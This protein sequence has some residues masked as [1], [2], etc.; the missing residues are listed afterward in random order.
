MNEIEISQKVR[1]QLIDI[2]YNPSDIFAEYLVNNNRVDIVI[3]D[4]GKPFIVIEVKNDEKISNLNEIE[5]RFNPAVRQAQH[6]ANLLKAPYFAV[7]NGITIKWYTIGHDGRPVIISGPVHSGND[8]NNSLVFK[9]EKLISF[10]HELRNYL[11]H[12]I[13]AWSTYQIS[14][15]VYSQILSEKGDT[16]LKNAVLKNE[17]EIDPIYNPIFNKETNF[18]KK[19][20]IEEVFFRLEKLEL[21]KQTPINLLVAIEEVFFKERDTLSIPRWLADLIAK[22]SIIDKPFRILDLHSGTGNILTAFNRLI[23]SA[24][25]EIT[26]C[27]SNDIERLSV[28]IQQQILGYKNTNIIAGFLPTISSPKVPEDNCFDIVTVA[29]PFGQSIPIFLTSFNKSSSDNLEIYFE[30]AL[31]F[32]K[33]NGI[34]TLIVP[35]GFLFSQKYNSLR[36]FIISDNS[37]L[38]IISLPIETFS[39]F[40]SV[41]TTLLVIQKT[42][43][44]KN[45]TLLASIT[46]PILNDTFESTSVKEID[47]IYQSLKDNDVKNTNTIKYISN[48][49]LTSKNLTYAYYFAQEKEIFNEGFLYLPLNNVTKIIKKGTKVKLSQNGR[50]PIIGPKSIRQLCINTE[51]YDYTDEGLLPQNVI[52]TEMEDILINSISTH[53]GETAIIDEKTKNIVISSNVILIRPIRDIILPEFLVL[54]LNSDAFRSKLKSITSGSVIPFITV[55]LLKDLILPIPSIE[56]QER[57]IIETNVAKRKLENSKKEYLNNLKEFETLILNI[58]KGDAEL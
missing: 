39:P 5:S 21:T 33:P 41:K 26:G 19:E 35:E 18:W 42:N 37:L 23:D 25:V 52:T 30:R 36:E 58:G 49:D 31:R 20:I 15:L 45:K 12:H 48:V 56:T 7:T 3:K 13:G 29:P 57:I 40:S 6:Y 10:F 32:C 46:K 24:E 17:I 55:N 16:R 38:A 50:V 1:N 53:I 28:L 22:I 2:G 8:P 51:N 43:K 27:T 54:L 9:K 34:I 11:A 44:K 14:L 47:N 4:N